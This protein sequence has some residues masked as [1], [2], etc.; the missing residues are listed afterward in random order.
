MATTEY[1]KL[2]D[3]PGG[4]VDEQN[5]LSSELDGVQNSLGLVSLEYEHEKGEKQDGVEKRKEGASRLLIP[6]LHHLFNNL[7]VIRH[8]DV[9]S[10]FFRLF[11]LF[12]FLFSFFYFFFFLS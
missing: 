9:N 8:M 5:F 10:G 12:L 2:F 3:F 11:L 4:M 1:I 7:M 6:T